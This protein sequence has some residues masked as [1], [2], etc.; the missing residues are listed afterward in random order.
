MIKP[1]YYDDFKCIAGA[2]RHNC[3]IGWEIDIDGE[4]LQKYQNADGDIQ[5][6]LQQNI[7]LEPCAH[8]V[9]AEDERCPFLNGDN[10]CALIL[11]GGEEMLCRI[12]SE[13]PR[14]YND[15]DGVTEVGLGLCCEAAAELI[16]TKTA[17]LKLIAEEASVLETVFFQDRAAIFAILQNRKM[18]LTERI[19]AALAE[20]NVV[21]P[22]GKADWIAVYKGL[23]RLDVAWDR[24]LDSLACVREEIPAGMDVMFEQLLCYFVYR[25]LSGAEDDFLFGERLQF[26]VLSCYMIANLAQSSADVLE[27]AR[28]YSA[29]IEYSDENV[30]VLLDALQECNGW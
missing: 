28:M 13:H 25:H 18:P 6:A 15:I 11:H 1:D 7:A 16:L 4:S 10:L 30:T 24:Y 2:C 21:S 8:F 19:T 14:F 3:C 17:P 12:C 29:E 5:H 22:I 23:E 26:A 20:A 9:L 27:V